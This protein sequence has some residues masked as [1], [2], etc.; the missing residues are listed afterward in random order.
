MLA[1]CVQLPPPNH[2][3]SFDIEN[4]EEWKEDY[5]QDVKGQTFKAA[6]FTNV[7]LSLSPNN[8]LLV[9][10]GS[11]PGYENRPHV[12]IGGFDGTTGTTGVGSSDPIK[13]ILVQAVVSLRAI[14]MIDIEVAPNECEVENE[15]K[16]KR[17]KR[18]KKRTQKR[19]RGICC[20]RDSDGIIVNSV[21]RLNDGTLVLIVGIFIIDQLVAKNFPCRILVLVAPLDPVVGEDAFL[22][23]HVS[24]M[25]L[26]VEVSDKLKVR[27]M[28]FSQLVFV[29]D[30]KREKLILACGPML[31]DRPKTVSN[32]F[33]AKKLN[34]ESHLEWSPGILNR[35]VLSMQHK[36]G[37]STLKK[38]PNLNESAILNKNERKRLMKQVVKKTTKNKKV[39]SSELKRDIP[40]QNDS[41]D[42]EV[43]VLIAAPTFKR[44]K[45]QVIHSNQSQAEER[46]AFEVRLMK[47]QL[48]CNQELAMLTSK[49]SEELNACKELN[50]KERMGDME[51]RLQD[52][53][54]QFSKRHE[55]MA[56]FLATS[57]E[58]SAEHRSASINLTHSVVSA[59]LKIDQNIVGSSSNEGDTKADAD[60]DAQLARLVKKREVI[61]AK[62]S[63]KLEQLS[64]TTVNDFTKKTLQDDLD[65]DKQDFVLVSEKVKKRRAELRDEEYGSL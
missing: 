13:A 36:P 35:S 38:K 11:N 10:D 26:V 55:D 1:G 19:S 57:L 51:M 33:T 22:V 7:K 64:A 48:Q 60:E 34:L 56:H 12:L 14:Q 25:H 54:E 20:N 62:I 42:S 16:R 58:T 5:F 9:A 63:E 15:N 45:N 43:E 40:S 17:N 8:Q 53:S 32:F 24:I 59:S 28:V 44:A 49:H 29:S 47:Q 21:R 4:P 18:I 52:S 65:E 46:D 2:G 37:P 6:G 31:T 30:E 50:F 61:S 3:S 27:E 41:S 23:S 39:C